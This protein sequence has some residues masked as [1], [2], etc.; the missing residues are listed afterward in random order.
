MGFG[1]IR[2][3][4]AGLVALLVGMPLTEKAFAGV[5]GIVTSGIDL[6]WSI[7]DLSGGES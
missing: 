3:Y 2:P 4:I 7:V 1:R 6:A 5:S